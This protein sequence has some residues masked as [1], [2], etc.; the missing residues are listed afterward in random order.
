MSDSSFKF[1]SKV[2]KCD[3]VCGEIISMAQSADSI[4]QVWEILDQNTGRA[5]GKNLEKMERT[6]NK[7]MVTESGTVVNDVVD[8]Q[9]SREPNSA[10]RQHEVKGF[11][12]FKRDFMVYPRKG[13]GRGR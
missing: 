13:I 3:V 11:R 6:V 10:I 2:L 8:E 5:I 7:Y 1:E 4:N 9:D 12:E